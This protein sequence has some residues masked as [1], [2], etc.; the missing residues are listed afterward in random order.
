MNHD[1]TTD[2][3][4]NK[5]ALLIVDD[6]ILLREAIRSTFEKCE[7]IEVVAEAGDGLEAVSSCLKLKPDVVLMDIMMP[8]LNGIEATKEIRRASPN[9]AVLVLTGY[10]DDAY[11]AG[12]LE[13]GAAGYLLK[14]TQAAGLIRA[15]RAIA[16]GETILD[17]S[18]FARIRHYITFPKKEESGGKV[19][20]A[21]NDSLSARELEVMRLVANGMS[22]KEIANR[23]CVTISTVKAHLSSIFGKIDVASRAEAIFK[24]MRLGLIGENDL[25]QRR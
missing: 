19:S 20:A 11:V 25:G 16:D 23:L 5:I 1:K 6:H 18:V 9:T 7:D 17:A 22:N 21:S 10:D 3:V 4:V 24:G 12:L 2:V 13:A 14:S 15:V 8:K